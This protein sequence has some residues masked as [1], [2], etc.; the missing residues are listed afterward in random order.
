M[1][2][3][4]LL[5]KQI[6]MAVVGLGYVGMPLALAFGEKFRVIGFDRNAEKIALY[7]S[8]QDPPGGVH[9]GRNVPA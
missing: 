9:V 7:H 1:Q 6:K 5:D 3:Q 2:F 4:K 8:G